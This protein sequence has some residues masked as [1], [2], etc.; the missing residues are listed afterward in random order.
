M[1]NALIVQ[2]SA[3]LD[4]SAHSGLLLA[5]GLREAGW[6]THVAFGFKGPIIDRYAVA[7]HETH[8]VPHNNWFRWDRKQ[9][10]EYVC[11]GWR[12][13]DAFQSQT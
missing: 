2:R 12:V 7:G 10:A 8:V 1:R 6:D 3:A 4:G 9:F 13:T 5:D 11:L